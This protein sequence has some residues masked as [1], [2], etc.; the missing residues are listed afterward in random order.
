[1]S[2]TRRDFAIAGTDKSL[3]VYTVIGAK[4]GPVVALTGAIHGDEYEGPITL[5]QLLATI[6]PA[7]LSGKLLVAPLSNPDAAS[8][9]Q[10]CSP[11]DGKNLA[12][13]FPG[14][15]DGTPTEIMADII[16]RE[17]IRPADALIDLHSGG[18]STDCIPFAGYGDAPKTGARAHA[19]AMAFGAPVVWRH[20]PPGS[21]GRTL[22]VAAEEGIPAIY[23]EAGGGPFPSDE[24]LALYAAG[25]RRVLRLLGSLDAEGEGEI[26]KTRQM[27]I[28]GAGDLDHAVMAPAS[29]IVTPLVGIMQPVKAGDLCFRITGLAGETLAELRAASDGLPIF[30][31]RTRWCETGDLLMAMAVPDPDHS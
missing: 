29:G 5:S 18:T 12:R 25:V 7:K 10:R 16:S 22:S 30:M 28:T 31:R 9:N 8:V 13:V 26:P 21:K 14:R 2:I 19:M 27:F 20:G 4:P 1:M 24:V 3:S 17:V 23:V 11:S 6:D 15:A